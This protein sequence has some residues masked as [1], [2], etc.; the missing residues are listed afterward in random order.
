VGA[1]AAFTLHL[2]RQL[3]GSDGTRSL[4]VLT[5]ILRTAGDANV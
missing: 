3:F 4:E 1:V 2:P 5:K